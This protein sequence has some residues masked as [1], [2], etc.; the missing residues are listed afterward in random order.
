MKR[1]IGTESL[2]VEQTASLIKMQELSRL[3]SCEFNPIRFKDQGLVVCDTSRKIVVTLRFDKSVEFDA[4]RIKKMIDYM[5]NEVCEECG[6]G[7]CVII[8][9][10]CSLAFCRDCSREIEDS[11]VVCPRG[12][13]S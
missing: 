8:C 1:E 3:V 13:V 12:C 6:V 10:S 5:G 4:R 2:S 7:I 11:N 9:S